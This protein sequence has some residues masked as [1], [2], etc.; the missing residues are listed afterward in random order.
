VI[1]EVARIIIGFQLVP[2]IFPCNG[3]HKITYHRKAYDE[4]HVTKILQKENGKDTIKNKR[5]LD[6]KVQTVYINKTS[7]NRI[8]YEIA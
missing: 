6:S 4:K 1:D 5:Q 3:K 7:K 8:K 2:V